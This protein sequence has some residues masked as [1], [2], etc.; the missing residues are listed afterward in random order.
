[1]HQRVNQ[2]ADEEC[3]RP[4]KHAPQSAK[5]ASAEQDFLQRG[6]NHRRPDGAEN[7]FDN[8]VR[9]QILNPAASAKPDGDAGDGGQREKSEQQSAEKFFRLA[10]RRNKADVATGS[11]VERVQHR[12]QPGERKNQK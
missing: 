4:V 5:N 8:F 11:R 7:N 2:A 9:Q 1:M 12:P 3:E 6:D 10:V